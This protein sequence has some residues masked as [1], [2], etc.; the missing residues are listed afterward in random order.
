VS[1]VGKTVLKGHGLQSE[2]K[3]YYSKDGYYRS[4]WL[5]DM[6][7]QYG[8]CACG[9]TFGPGWSQSAIKRAHRTHKDQIRA[10]ET[11]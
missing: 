2:G 6:D 3:P 4:A 10:E 5:S 1:N 11:Q 7:R 9:E 8:L